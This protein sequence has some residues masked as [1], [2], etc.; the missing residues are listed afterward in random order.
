MLE[1]ISQLIRYWFISIICIEN[2]VFFRLAVLLAKCNL[3]IKLKLQ[4]KII[5]SK[6]LKFLWKIKKLFSCHISTVILKSITDDFETINTFFKPNQ[7]VRNSLIIVIH[8]WSNYVG[9]YISV[10]IKVIYL[11]NEMPCGKLMRLLKV[12]PFLFFNL[13][14]F[15]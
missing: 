2:N 5:L 6:I 13:K 4:P 11:Q 7:V 3:Y 10:A 8:F 15:L 14:C 1:E 9:S 12:N